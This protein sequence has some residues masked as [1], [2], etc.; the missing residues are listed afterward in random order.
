MCS[1]TWEESLVRVVK[2]RGWQAHFR[3]VYGGPRKKAANLERVAS[4]AGCRETE[5][6]V[7]GDTRDDFDAAADKGC[8]CRGGKSGASD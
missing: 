1:G 8:A 2:A 5:L 7:V 6:L 4:H 3:G